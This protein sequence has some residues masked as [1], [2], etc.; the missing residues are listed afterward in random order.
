MSVPLA[1]IK[2]GARTETR[3]FDAATVRLNNIPGW[4]IGIMP[5]DIEL[6]LRGIDAIAYVLYP[7]EN[8]VERIPIEIKSSWGGVAYHK[9]DHPDLARA[10]VVYIVIDDSLE[11]E[12]VRRILYAELNKRR[13]RNIRFEKFL[14]KFLAGRLRPRAE[15]RRQNHYASEMRDLRFSGGGALPR[16]LPPLLSEPE[17]EERTF[18]ERVARWFFPSRDDP[19]WKPW[20]W[21]LPS[22]W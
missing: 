10:D 16:T 20:S 9:Q 1:E 4:L 22:H 6:D 14:T 15:R 17:L 5:A 8:W 13:T 11:D 21:M 18:L 19:D 7:N 12:D 2:K 3:F